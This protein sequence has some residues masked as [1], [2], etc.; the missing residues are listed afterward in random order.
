[1]IGT[2]AVANIL[3]SKADSNNDKQRLDRLAGTLWLK[4]KSHTIED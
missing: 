2:R 3:V 4:R 1:M